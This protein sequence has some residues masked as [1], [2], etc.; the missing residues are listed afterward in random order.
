MKSKMLAAIAIAA[1]LSLAAAGTASASQ[2]K[3]PQVTG[4]RLLSALLPGSAF[5]ADPTQFSTAST[6]SK[7][8]PSSSS[9]KVSTTSCAVFGAANFTP[10]FGKT[11]Q[12]QAGYINGNPKPDWPFTSFG[13]IEWVS[14]FASA[15]AA[16]TF[17]SQ[18]MAK[19]K[20]CRSYTEPDPTGANVPGGGEQDISTMS[21]YKTTAGKYKAFVVEQLSAYSI[22]NGNFFNINTLIALAGTNVYFLSDASGANDT[23]SRALMVRLINRVQKLY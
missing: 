13:C 18:S 8:W 5:V 19:Y 9:A 6:G 7:L 16:A 4:V 11:A 17:F 21:V 14:Q 10:A 15:Q 3:A 20:A 2:R 12:A 1:G 23:P 22:E